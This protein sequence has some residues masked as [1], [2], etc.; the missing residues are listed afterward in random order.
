M[1]EQI[2]DLTSGRQAGCQNGPVAAQTVLVVDDEVEIVEILRDY[3]EAGGFQVVTATDGAEAL[4]VSAREPVD[5][6]VLDVMMPGPSGF[7]V[8]RQLRASSDVPVLFLSARDTDADKIRGLGLGDDYIVKTASP[9]EIVARVRTVLRRARR[10]VA[11][12]N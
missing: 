6:L 3:L 7:E 4:A 5:C 1:P 10:P 11:A 12:A 9:A 8:C 2:A